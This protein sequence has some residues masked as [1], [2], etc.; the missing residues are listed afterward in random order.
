MLVTESNKDR[1]D[2]IPKRLKRNPNFFYHRR[3]AYSILTIIIF[4]LTITATCLTS[5]L[6]LD[7]NG[8]NV[9]IWSSKLYEL[10]DAKNNAR[11]G[12]KKKRKKS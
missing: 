12:N 9:S 7:D 5:W 8:E 3:I 1:W 2:P 11:R 10:L 4:L 6:V